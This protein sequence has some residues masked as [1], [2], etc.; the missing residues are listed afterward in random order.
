VGHDSNRVFNSNTI[1]IVSH[2]SG[3][4][5]LAVFVQGDTA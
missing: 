4:F 1:G 5:D 2:N 3:G